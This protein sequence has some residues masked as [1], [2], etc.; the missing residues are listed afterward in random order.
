[1]VKS[2]KRAN[3]HTATLDARIAACLASD[4]ADGA[5]LVALVQEAEAAVAEAQA[6]VERELAN[7]LDV[8]NADPDHSDELARKAERTIARLDRA[9]PQLRERI[10]SL[11]AR[12]YRE[13]WN[14]AGDKLA[15]ERDALADELRE[16]YP[17]VIAQLADIFQR[18]DANAAAIGDL[19][20]RAPHG[21]HRRLLDAELVARDLPNYDAV[22]PRLR[23]GLRLPNWDVSR[24]IAFPVPIDWNQQAALATAAFASR[25]TE[26]FALT[27]GPDWASAR[28]SQIAEEQAEA[29]KK[30]D[31]LKQAE[32]ESLAE[33]MRHQ[34][35]AELRRR[36]LD[37]EENVG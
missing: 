31:E 21:E 4:D 28:E 7:A 6:T 11:E 1:M 33:Y 32:A 27:C 12:E 2:I 10:R 18:I 20:G 26:K 23:D 14:A 5:E 24:D 34:R 36:G 25:L 29:A 16:L 8:G 35:E 15:I 13:R 30:A 3:G 22:H 19:H 9:L 17:A 37:P